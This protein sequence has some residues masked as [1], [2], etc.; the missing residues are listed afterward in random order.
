M[1]SQAL[2][3]KDILSRQL[4]EQLLQFR[5]ILSQENELPHTMPLHILQWLDNN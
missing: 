5:I 3:N 2:L 1:L 4:V